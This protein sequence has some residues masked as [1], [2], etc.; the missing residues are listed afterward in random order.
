MPVDT[1]A[2]IQT[3]TPW[4]MTPEQL[5]GVWGEVEVNLMAETQAGS[6]SWVQLLFHMHI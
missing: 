4:Q 5:R 2:G 6:L 1:P 3:K